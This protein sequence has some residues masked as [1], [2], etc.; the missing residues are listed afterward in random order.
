[1][2]AVV[3]FDNVPDAVDLRDVPEPETLAWGQVLLRV[4]AAS[5]CGSDVHQW[6]NKQSWKVNVPVI[7]GHEFCGTIEAVGAGVR[8]F[9]PGE[10]VACETAARVC[11]TCVYCRTGRYNLCPH[12]LGYG[13]GVDGAFAR[14]VVANPELLH[15]IP[16]SVNFEF[17][18]LTEPLSVAVNALIERAR[19]KPG[20]T[21]GIVGPGPIGLMCVQ[22]ARVCGASEIVLIGL[23]RDQPRLELGRELGATKLVNLEGEDPLR[24]VRGLGDGFGVDLAVDTTGVSSSLKLCIEAVRPAGQIAK[25][26]WGPQPLDF[27]LDPLVQKAVTLHGSFSHAYAT[28]ERSL[29]LM[30]SGAVKLQPMISAVLPLEDW[31]RGFAGMEDGKLVKAVLR[32]E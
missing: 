20:E 10:R 3:K 19:I 7:M 28:W 16:E 15:R 18:S 32:P 29:Q 4:Q 21:V 25:I 24:V 9:Q 31:E 8:E 23:E 1:M 30:A 22:V 11:G 14:Y 5:V 6:R 2:K 26:G 17:A 12:R 27:S 13:Y